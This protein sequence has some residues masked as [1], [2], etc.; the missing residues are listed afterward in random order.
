MP[1]IF[2]N[3]VGASL[4]PQQKKKRGGGGADYEHSI[5]FQFQQ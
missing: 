3:L 1:P 4:P 2:E 5:K